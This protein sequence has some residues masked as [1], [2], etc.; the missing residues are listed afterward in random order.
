MSGGSLNYF[1]YQLEDHVG[2]FDDKEL[3]SLV[4]DLAKLFKDR[5]WYLSADTGKGSWVEARDS[6]K[7]KWFTEHG[8]QER[9]EQYLNEFAD[10][11][12]D[13][14]GLKKERCMNCKHWSQRKDDSPYGN[15]ELETDYMLHRAESCGKYEGREWH[16][17]SDDI[18]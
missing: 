16:G 10:E 4:A 2:D 1:Y 6:F 13:S 7:K 17:R 12:R 3:D 15:C 8:R 5:E 11:I 9:I 18:S 14:F